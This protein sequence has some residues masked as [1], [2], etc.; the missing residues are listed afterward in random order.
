[1][2]AQGV[3]VSFDATA[4]FDYRNV[5]DVGFGFRSQSGLVALLRVDLF[6]YVTLAYAYDMA[7]S[8]IRFDGRHTHEVVLGFQACARGET[9]RVVPCAAYD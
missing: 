2:F 7:L 5:V 9:G 4:V 6:K 1:M 8:R 3:P